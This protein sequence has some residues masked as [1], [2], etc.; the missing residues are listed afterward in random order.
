MLSSRRRRLVAAALALLAVAAAVA[1]Y[2]VLKARTG[3]I[4]HPNVEF[5]PGV[6]PAPAPTQ[7]RV[8]W[9]L[10][11]RTPDH[12][13]NFSAPAG[14]R[15]PFVRRWEYSG[16]V[17]L[18]FPPV[19]SN[20]TIYQLND[21]AILAAVDQETGRLRWRRRLGALS[22][23][24]P[25]VGEGRVY[26]T[27]LERNKGGSAGRVV[28]L[29]ARSGKT[30]WSRDVPSRTESSPL[31]DRGYIYFG[32][33]SGRVYA[34]SARTGALRWAYG[35]AGAVKGSPS[36]LNGVLYFGDY[37]GHVHAVREDSGHRVWSVG[38]SGARFG[39]GSGQFYSTAALAFG[40]VFIGNTDG[41]VYSFAQRSGRLAWAT[42]T[43]GYVYASPAVANVPGL[44][45]TVYAGS[46]DGTFYAFDARSGRVRWRY[47]AGGKIS[48]SATI[49]GGIIYFANLADRSTIGLD[50]RSGR[51]LFA[52]QQ[53]GFDPVISD[54]QR[55]YLS[56]YRSLYALQPRPSG[57]EAAI[58][59]ARA[60]GVKVAPAP[61]PRRGG[62]SHRR[63][64]TRRSGK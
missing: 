39:F 21:D 9:P 16:G 3:N 49:V 10:Y 11:G 36:L 55:I 19:I 60:G 38:T 41:R 4:S 32:S 30:I 45:P 26:V 2:A 63:R 7:R 44:G 15:P 17:L 14:L 62:A 31:L 35:A 50:V 20:G 18:E 46:Y 42:G 47:G 48:G 56:G 37:S 52:T 27:I 59:I 24:A 12:T 5:L 53:G 43:G 51:R 54:G 28:A 40:R 57:R 58:A 23:S 61:R 34:R 33:Q 6:T 13:R 1:A 8:D 22:A 64:G 25:A 29:D